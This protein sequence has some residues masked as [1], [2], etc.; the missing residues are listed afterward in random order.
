M[1]YIKTKTK[2]KSDGT[3]FLEIIGQK[4]KTFFL[5]VKFFLF[6]RAKKKKRNKKF[7]PFTI[8]F[9]KVSLGYYYIHHI[10]V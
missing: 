8:F 6:T 2:K 3:I 10:I 7:I 1:K 4:Q 9:H 5:I